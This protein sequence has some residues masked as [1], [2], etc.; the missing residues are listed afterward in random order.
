MASEITRVCGGDSAC[1]TSSTDGAASLIDPFGR[2]I[3]YLRLSV[4]DRCDFRC[5][6]CMAEDVVFLPKRDVLSLEELE[7]LSLAFISLGVRKLRITG[8]EPLVRRDVMQLFRSLGTRLG[9]DLDELTLTTNGSQLTRFAVPLV[10]AGVRRINVSLDTLDAERFRAVT[11]RGNLAAVLAGLEAARTA[12]LAVKLNAVVVGGVNENECASLV[13]WAG[14]RGFDITFI[15]IMPMGEL[16]PGLRLSQY[17]PLTGVRADLESRFTLTPSA[18]RTGGP[19][20]Y[21]D[22]RELGN[23]VGFIT[24]LTGNF[25]DGCN[26]VRVSCTGTLYP[27]LGQDTARELREVL[28]ANPE[29]DAPLHQA[30]RETIARKPHG[31]DFV[32]D[33][34]RGE[35]SVSR[36]MHTTG[37]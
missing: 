9:T 37:G 2:K 23:T 7:R 3:S 6:Y 31:H 20:R 28:R 12:G 4:T 30:I 11:R 25:C 29:D 19:A 34:R 13:S 10:E 5:N 22:V 21:W 16:A 1:T 36:S 8:G 33:A 18:Q 24:P 26:R 35:V 27:C 14:S 15:E 17:R 32:L